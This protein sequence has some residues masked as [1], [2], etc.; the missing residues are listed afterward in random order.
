MDRARTNSTQS[1]SDDLSAMKI[2]KLKSRTYPKK[3]Q[4][5][6]ESRGLVVE[7]WIFRNQVEVGS[8]WPCNSV[9]LHG[10]EELAYPM[11][12]QLLLAQ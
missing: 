3:F 7:R 10:S 8:G 12:N 6:G 2:R 9:V 11:I 4:R 1:G 5:R